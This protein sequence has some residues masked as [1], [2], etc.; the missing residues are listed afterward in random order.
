MQLCDLLS[1][2]LIIENIS[3]AVS[4][5]RY[6]LP[7]V[8]QDPEEHYESCVLFYEYRKVII[9]LHNEERRTEGNSPLTYDC[10]LEHPDAKLRNAKELGYGVYKLIG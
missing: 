10:E 9:D 5:A 3:V 6:M 2:I 7:P 8:N 1:I 4:Q